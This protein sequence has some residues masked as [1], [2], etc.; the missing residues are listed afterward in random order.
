MQ[1]VDLATWLPGDILRKAD[2][3]SMAHSLE[4]RV[5]FLDPAVFAAAAATPTRLA[6]PRGTRMTKVALRRALRDVVPAEVV[7]RPKLGFPT[8][9][10]VW[11]RGPMLGWAEHILAN[12]AAVELVDL[13]YGLQLLREHRDGEADHSRKI[14]TLLV[15]ALWYDIFVNGSLRSVPEALHKVA[16]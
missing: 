5:P 4:V 6:L 12:S 9:I 11:L 15:F 16:S 13:S 14:W 3:M 8:P 10:R 7:T 1:L 2:R